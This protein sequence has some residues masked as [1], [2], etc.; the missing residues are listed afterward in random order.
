MSGLTKDP[1]LAF[2]RIALAIMFGLLSFA[3]VMVAI[4]VGALLTVQHGTIAADIAA[5]GLPPATIWGIAA[6]LVGIIAMLFL[7]L[8]FVV[9]LRRIVGSVDDGDPF[10]PQN[11]ERLARMGWLVLAIHAIGIPLA[12]AA[13][14]LSKLTEDGDIDASFSSGGIV[15][16]LTLFILARVF[17]KGTEMRTELEGTV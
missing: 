8:R 3:M 12:V 13:T 6:G 7:A 17:R 4:G 1:L 11:A 10:I 14:W 16:V 5:A 9:E 15:L 2:A